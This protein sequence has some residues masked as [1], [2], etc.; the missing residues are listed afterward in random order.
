MS[1]LTFPMNLPVSAEQ[2]LSD[3]PDLAV[4]YS[5]FQAGSFNPND[6]LN[7]GIAQNWNWEHMWQ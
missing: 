1:D 5:A 6:P 4:E 2:W 3:L 7:F